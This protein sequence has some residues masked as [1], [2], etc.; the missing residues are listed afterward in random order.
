MGTKLREEHRLMVLRRIFAPQGHE[1]TGGW[2]GLHNELHNFQFSP[3]IIRILQS[4][5]EDVARIKKRNAYRLLVGKPE[6]MRSLGKPRRRW[7]DN[8]NMDLGE[9]GWVVWTELVLFRIETSGRLL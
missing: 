3:R 2:G 5:A 8:L 6:G 7:L 4:L 9:I 1:V